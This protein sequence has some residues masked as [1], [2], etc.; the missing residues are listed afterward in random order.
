MGRALLLC[1]IGLVFHSSFA[2]SGNNSCLPVLAD[3]VD[4]IGILNKNING[5]I[6]T[7][8]EILIF[9]NRVVNE[10]IPEILGEYRKTVPRIQDQIEDVT[11]EVAKIRKLAEDRTS[12]GF[13]IAVAIGAAFTAVVTVIVTNMAVRWGRQRWHNYH[14]RSPLLPISAPMVEVSEI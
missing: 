11:R 5:T 4:E 7:V 10:T 3:A 13:I 2:F 12:A 9:A 14:F 1:T 6:L 8:G